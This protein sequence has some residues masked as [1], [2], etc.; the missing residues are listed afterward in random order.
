MYSNQD[1][2]RMLRAQSWAMPPGYDADCLAAQLFTQD[3]C[4]PKQWDLVIALPG[5]RD[6]AG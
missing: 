2:I 5:S 6:Y 3:V 4:V 1:K